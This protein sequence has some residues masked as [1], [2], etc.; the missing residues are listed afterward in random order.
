M[1]SDTVYN[2]FY[3]HNRVLGMI[4]VIPNTLS[5]GIV[6]FPMEDNQEVW[7][8]CRQGMSHTE[9]HAPVVLV[10]SDTTQVCGGRHA[11]DTPRPGRHKLLREATFPSRI[12]LK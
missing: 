12:L 11:R 5:I 9:V 10:K 4:G 3:N 6:P 1:D 2:H 8:S 7:F